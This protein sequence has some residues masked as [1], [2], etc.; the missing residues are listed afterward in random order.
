MEIKR[1]DTQWVQ[2]TCLAIRPAIGEKADQLWQMYLFAD[3][4]GRE[5]LEEQ[6]QL[7]AN[8][9]LHRDVQNTTPVFRT[10]EPESVAGE[11]NVG[12]VIYNGKELYPMGL[13]AR[14]IAEHTAIAGRSGSGKTTLAFHL[15]RN[16]WKQQGVPW[17]VLDWK[18]SWRDLMLLSEFS[19]MRV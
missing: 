5:E 14:Q 4:K 13:T 12:N 9:L 3:E 1:P 18:R 11:F 6:L 17:L 16:L 15:A 10:P 7:L 19:D 2:E 8:S